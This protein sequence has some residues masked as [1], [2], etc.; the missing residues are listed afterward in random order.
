M[1][2]ETPVGAPTKHPT[3]VSGGLFPVATLPET[4]AQRNPDA[5]RGRLNGKRPAFVD[6]PRAHDVDIADA[7]ALIR[8]AARG[9]FRDARRHDP[10]VNRD[11]TCGELTHTVAH[12]VS[13]AI[14]EEWEAVDAYCTAVADAAI[15]RAF[16]GRA[17]G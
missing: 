4:V 8:Q 5:L 10:R 12:A 16:E 3:G 13:R 6:R 17:D 1:N 11:M 14:G 2:S 7:L 15:L 9:Y